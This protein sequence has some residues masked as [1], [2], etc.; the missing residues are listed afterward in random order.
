MDRKHEMTERDL[1]LEILP[2]LATHDERFDN[3]IERLDAIVEYQ[4]Q[5]NG[6]VFALSERIQQHDRQLAERT[7]TCPLLT[8]IKSDI[9]KIQI[10]MATR[11]EHQRTV[12]A[13]MA[14][15]YACVGGLVAVVGKYLLD[16]VTHK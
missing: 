2:K 7:D 5:Q 8:P 14:G 15:V 10:E 4:K 13:I 3:V 12:K 11:A 1:L 9:S 16:L 6:R